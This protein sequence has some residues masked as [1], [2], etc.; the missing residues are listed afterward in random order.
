MFCIF[1]ELNVRKI[2]MIGFVRE[3]VRWNPGEKKDPEG[4]AL[5]RR[6]EGQKGPQESIHALSGTKTLRFLKR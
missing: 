3:G 4:D 2:G 1:Y 6:A 5:R